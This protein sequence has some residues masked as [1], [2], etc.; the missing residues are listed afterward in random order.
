M[1]CSKP[2][3]F[4]VENEAVYVHAALVSQCSEPL[5]K[6]MKS[7]MME[8]NQGKVTIEDVD[9]GTFVRFVQWLYHGYY[10]AATPLRVRQSKA[11]QVVIE[12]LQPASVEMH[13]TSVPEAAYPAAVEDEIGNGINLVL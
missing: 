8:G 13:G 5:D 11:S 7:P 12:I 9:L 3:E 6:M 4:I 1:Y 10:E 2:F